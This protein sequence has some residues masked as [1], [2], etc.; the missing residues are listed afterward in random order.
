LQVDVTETFTKRHDFD[1]WTSRSRMT[2]GDR[3]RLERMLLDADEATRARFEVEMADGHL[4]AFKDT[5][6]LF[7]ARRG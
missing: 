5:K 7:V 6:T 4:L 2:A 1:D 3:A